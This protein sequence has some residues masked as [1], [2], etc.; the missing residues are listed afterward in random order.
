MND[1]QNIFTPEQFRVQAVELS[2]AVA[3]LHRR[4][5][6]C[7]DPHD[8]FGNESEFH[9]YQPDYAEIVPQIRIPGCQIP[10]RPNRR[11]KSRIHRYY[12]IVGGFMLGHL[13]LNLFLQ[14]VLQFVLL[15]LL[16]MS[17]SA[18]AGGELPGNYDG[19]AMQYFM[20]SS[21]LIALNM[22]T[23]GTANIL[24]VWLGC[25]M[26][27]ISVPNLFRTQNFTAATA[28]CYITVAALLHLLSG[29][30]ATGLDSLFQGVGVQLFESPEFESSDIKG[31]VLSCV[32]SVI[33]AP[34][35]EELLMR[36]F[37]LKNLSRVS[38]RFGI[39]TSAF[40]FGLWHQNLPQFLLAFF[41]GLLLGYITVK[42]N[43]ILPAIICHMSINALSEVNNVMLERGWWTALEVLNIVYLAMGLV[44]LV[45]LIRMCIVE[46][47]PQTT[48]HQ[49]ERTVRQA[50]A[51]PL[52][53][54]A[55][56]CYIVSTA[57]NIIVLNS[58]LM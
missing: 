13:L 10:L 4:D 46:R 32:Y 35:T 44:G 25:R 29:Q 17:D 30:A 52:F 50:W 38:Q 58:S 3:E 43:S 27:K 49:S 9:E 51:S 57:A 36:G 22:L 16:Q 56:V 8:P 23:Y 11:E 14:M 19:M 48:P 15:A 24:T 55:I 26:T 53:V 42:H 12:N 34:V 28:F 45:L 6:Q 54:T 47:M 33:V 39:F 20:N 18:A 41:V 37:V 5:S 1:P 21:S 2:Q 7:I 31:A 40:L